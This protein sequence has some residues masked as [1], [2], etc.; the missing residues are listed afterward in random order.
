MGQL[1]T[2]DKI[3]YKYVLYSLSMNQ[4][5]GEDINNPE[6]T[7]YIIHENTFSL[8]NAISISNKIKHVPSYHQYFCPIVSSTSLDKHFHK[9]HSNTNKNNSGNVSANV[10]V[11]SVQYILIHYES[12]FQEFPLLS[13]IYISS[14][15]NPAFDYISIYF[16]LLESIEL[17]N[18]YNIVCFCISHSS[19]IFDT[20]NNST[21]ICD[22]TNSFYIPSLHY[23]RLSMFFHEGVI[24]DNES[25]DNDYAC[26]CF[27]VYFISYLL[28]HNIDEITEKI[29]ENCVNEFCA[30]RSILKRHDIY[31][32]TEC[33]NGYTTSL[34]I[35][36]LLQFASSWSIYSF[37]Y[38]YYLLNYTTDNE[39][40]FQSHISTQIE[41]YLHCHPKKRIL[42][43]HNVLQIVS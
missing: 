22:F 4:E 18:K 19:L 16:N 31:K 41:D 6:N 37:N 43:F 21:M 28:F 14:I 11:N 10:N 30:T 5:H 38:Y 33:L 13:D 35:Q 29:L 20:S 1:V 39:H 12:T 27:D 2:F 34:V 32:W 17:L 40:F 7:Y 25:H 3:L 26:A 15:L 9:C 36:Y 24:H 8:N 23:D 42:D